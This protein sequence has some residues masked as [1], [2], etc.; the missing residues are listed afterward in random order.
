MTRYTP[1]WQQAGNYPA[2][3]DRAL[4]ATL[5]PVNAAAGA[6][7]AAVTNTMNVSIPSGAIAVPLQ[8][9]QHTALCRWDA[10]EVVSSPAAPAAGN[11]RIDVVIAQVR[12]PALDAGVNNDFIFLVVAGTPTTG[13]P[14]A[15]AVPANAAAVCQ[16]TVPGGAA[17]LNG[18]TI[19][20][21]RR[22]IGTVVAFA[23]VAERDALWPSP[24]PGSVCV[25]LDSEILWRRINGAWINVHPLIQSA[26]VLVTTDGFGNAAVSLP[27]GAKSISAVAIGSQLSYPHLFNLNTQDAP[28]GGSTVMFNVRDTAGNWVQNA[29]ITFTYVIT[30]T[31]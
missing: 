21:R 18:V 22:A 11:S 24:P 8:S 9:G 1:L 23:S 28:L 2:N 19:T 26:D 31:Y 27:A 4:L 13:T 5:W 7:P 12:D 6:K 25:T 10:A 16:Y 29:T 3:Y 17:N 20:D 30:Y 15:P 14:A